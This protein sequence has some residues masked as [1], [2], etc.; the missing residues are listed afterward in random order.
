MAGEAIFDAIGCADCHVGTFAADDDEGLEGAIR[1]QTLHPYSDFLIHD[2]GTN[3]DFI[4]QGGAGITELRTTPLWGLR[5]RDPLWH[6][7]RVAGGTFEFRI[8]SVIQTHDANGSEAAASAQAFAALPAADQDAL[9]AFMDSLGRQEFDMNGDNIVDDFDAMVIDMICANTDMISPD[10]PCAVADVDQN[11]IV[12]AAD[13][14]LL[15]VVLGVVGDPTDED[16]DGDDEG[17]DDGNF[18]Y[19]AIQN[20]PGNGGI[21]EV[22]LGPDVPTNNPSVE[23]VQD[24]RTTNPRR[25]GRLERRGL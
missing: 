6:D 24:D 25:R 10:D 12:D 17:T 20:P 11:G 1:G 3:G 19:E 23:P 7:G 8:N 4:E 13:L 9:I 15:D 21:Q 2:A 18:D 22:G 5:L 14:A 16:E